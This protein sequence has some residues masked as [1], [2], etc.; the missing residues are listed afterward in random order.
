VITEVTALVGAWGGYFFL[1]LY[2]W[3]N[4]PQRPMMT[5]KSW[6]T[7]DVLIGQPPFL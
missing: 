1:P 3:I 7:S 2:T 6:R 4:R 5:R